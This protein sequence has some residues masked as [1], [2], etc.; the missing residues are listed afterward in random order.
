[1][2]LLQPFHFE[3]QKNR[4]LSRDDIIEN[5]TMEVAGNNQVCPGV[6]FH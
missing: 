4:A 2:W 5:L 3:F 1:V 6:S